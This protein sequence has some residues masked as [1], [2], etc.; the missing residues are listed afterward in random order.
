MKERNFI[1][2]RPI[3]KRAKV[4]S[5]ADAQ[6]GDLV[7]FFE[8][9]RFTTR[10]VQDVLPARSLIVTAPLTGPYGVL[11]ESTKVKFEDIDEIM[12]P[13]VQTKASG[14]EPEPP[15][16]EEM[17]ATPSTAKASTKITTAPGDIR[18]PGSALR[19]GDPGYTKRPT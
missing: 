13:E 8:E 19:P 18:V 6:R 3:G 11:A 14:P 15:P 9:G 4:G 16:P 1:Y 7:V 12:R 2:R 5:P 17:A 10:E